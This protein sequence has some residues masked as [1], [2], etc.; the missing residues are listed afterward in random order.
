MQ[1]LTIIFLI[2]YLFLVRL[3]GTI[4]EPHDQR[5]YNYLYIHLFINLWNIMFSSINL[6]HEQIDNVIASIIS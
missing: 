5:A 4:F 2:Q 3:S 1:F 6:L